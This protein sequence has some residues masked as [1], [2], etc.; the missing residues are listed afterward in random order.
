M[1]KIVATLA[2]IASIAGIAS[3]VMSVTDQPW[4]CIA[5]IVGATLIIAYLLQM[6]NNM[7]RK[8]IRKRLEECAKA[9]KK[10]EVEFLGDSRLSSHREGG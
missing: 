9:K 1:G 4:S 2:F 5:L 6:G 8:G 3:F 7:Y 10:L